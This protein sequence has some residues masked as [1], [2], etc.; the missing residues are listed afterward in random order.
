VGFADGSGQALPADTVRERS[1]ILVA[2]Q[3]GLREEVSAAFQLR[4]EASLRGVSR[5]A[6]TAALTRAGLSDDLHT[7][8]VGRL[9][10]GQ[11][12]RA[13]LARLFLGEARIWLLDEADASLDGCGLAMLGEAV[14]I[15]RAGG[16]MVVAA[17][18]SSAEWLG[19]H[20]TLSLSPV[21]TAA[22]TG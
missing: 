21:E 4:I 5:E 9:S 1:L 12:R 11:L 14:R 3:A 16:G 15:H 20:R 22:E 18:H 8:A 2:H 19:E 6:V 13:A 7:V 10:A 17:V